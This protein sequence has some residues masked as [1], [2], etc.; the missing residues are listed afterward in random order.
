MTTDMYSRAIGHQPL[1]VICNS[2]KVR[3]WEVKPRRQQGSMGAIND[4]GDCSDYEFHFIVKCD[5]TRL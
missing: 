3:I 2:R 4:D 5:F 1:Y